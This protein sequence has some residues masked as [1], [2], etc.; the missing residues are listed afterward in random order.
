MSPDGALATMLMGLAEPADP[1][2][3]GG[4]GAAGIAIRESAQPGARG[5]FLGLTADHRPLL[6][7]RTEARKAEEVRTWDRRFGPGSVP[8][9]LKVEREGEYLTPFASDDGFGWFQLHVPIRFPRFPATAF[10]GIAVA[11]APRIPVTAVFNSP[12]VAGAWSSVR[13]RASA[14]NGSALLSWTEA[15]GAAGYRVRR[16]TAATAAFGTEL[17]SPEPIRETSFT[18]MGLPNGR[19]IRY[20][21]TPL[22]PAEDGQVTEGWTT[23]TSVTPVDTP[24]GLFGCD[25]GGEIPAVRG[26]LVYE[27]PAAAYRVSGTGRS[28]WDAADCG[29]MGA[30]WMTGDFQITSVLLG[31][32]SH[33]GG[34]MVREGLAG[35][36]RFF[37]LAG[38]SG[39]G[40]VLLSRARDGAR[41]RASRPLIPPKRFQPPLVLRLVRRGSTLTGFTSL[42]GVAFRPAGRPTTFR[43]P[44]PESLAVGCFAAGSSPGGLGTA[45]FARLSFE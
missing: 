34:L 45:R 32:P 44:L 27:A 24:L 31:R 20:L 38:T 23:A 14:G 36:V 19:A 25:L 1:L 13:L 40:L 5:L 43:P 6:R 30:R 12:I 4:S 10:A 18:D 35:P 41:V 39:N 15:P 21:V 3:D 42:D 17:L 9:W 11:S 28:D 37:A 33:L 2:I 29:H 26:A 7:F 22:F 8:I 16:V